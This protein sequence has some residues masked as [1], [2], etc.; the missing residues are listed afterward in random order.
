MIKFSKEIKVGLTVLVSLFILGWGIN[1]LKGNDLFVTGYK[2]YGVYPRIDGLTESGPIYYKGFKIGS[3]RD[4]VL[5]ESRGGQI[6]VAMS[7]DE[8]ISFP[9]NTIAQI[10]SLDLMGA[11]G[12]RFLYGS[13][14]EC[15]KS[16]DT[17]LTSLS[18]GFADQV[19]QEVLPI[20][21]KAENLIVKLDSVLTNLNS[22]FDDGNKESFSSG[23]EN[24]GLMMNN[25]NEISSSMNTSFKENGAINNSLS[26]LDSFTSVLRSNG[27][28]LSNVMKN[29]EVVSTQLTETHV[30]SLV[31]EMSFAISSVNGVLTSLNN[32]EG[33]LGLLLSDEQLYTNL[34]EVAVSLDRLLNDVRHR[35][36]RYVK[37][38]AVSFGGGKDAVE[39]SNGV[40]YKVLLGKSKSPLDLRGKQLMDD[41]YVFEDREG[42]YFIYTIGEEQEYDSILVIYNEIVAKY[43]DAEIVA[44]EKGRL[45]KIK[46]GME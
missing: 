32:G 39:A 8:D 43:P 19:S 11:K 26:N 10:Y 27:Q 24:F 28:V 5:D 40:V 9:K 31:K 20:K 1:F 25:L 2:L 41:Q 14:R 42:K 21:D 37:F 22:V 38:S 23:I 16:K 7:I 3:V 18:G 45:K 34:N 36:K 35:P 15:L 33:S 44:V 6:V 4:I 13:E 30:D 29:L 12:I 46:S 17:I